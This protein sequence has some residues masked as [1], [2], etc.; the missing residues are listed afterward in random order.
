MLACA[1]LRLQLLVGADDV[2][3]QPL[4]LPAMLLQELLLWMQ[5]IW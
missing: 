4:A 2:A 5:K 1:H 3:I